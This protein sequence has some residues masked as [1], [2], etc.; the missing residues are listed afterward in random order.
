M[1]VF[2]RLLFKM[3][4]VWLSSAMLCFV[5]IIAYMKAVDKMTPI[6]AASQEADMDDSES[7]D[8]IYTR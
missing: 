7:D 6:S 2:A 4:V 3:C 8:Y 1:H 5:V